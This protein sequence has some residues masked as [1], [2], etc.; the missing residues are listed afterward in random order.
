MF[1][2]SWKLVE[3]E[4]IRVAKLFVTPLKVWVDDSWVA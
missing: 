1:P 2:C 4:Q 3:E